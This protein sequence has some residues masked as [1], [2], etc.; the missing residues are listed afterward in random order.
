MRDGVSGGMVAALRTSDAAAVPSL[1]LAPV[2]IRTSA[3]VA[4]LF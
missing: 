3:A 2:T 1:A 4:V